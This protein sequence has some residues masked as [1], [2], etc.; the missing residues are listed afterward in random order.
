MSVKQDSSLRRVSL[1]D[2]QRRQQ[3]SL[4]IYASL[5][6][7]SP[8]LSSLSIGLATGLLG[9]FSRRCVPFLSRANFPFPLPW[10]LQ[11]ANLLQV[12]LPPLLEVEP[13]ALRW[14]LRLAL[15]AVHL[16]R[17]EDG[18]EDFG[19]GGGGGGGGSGGSGDGGGGSSVGDVGD[20]EDVA[21]SCRRG[22][23]GSLS[24]SSI[25]VETQRCVRLV[26]ALLKSARAQG[27]LPAGALQQAPTPTRCTRLYAR[28]HTEAAP[29]MPRAHAHESCTRMNRA[30]SVPADA[31]DVACGLAHSSRRRCCRRQVEADFAA[32]RWPVR[33]SLLGSALLSNDETLGLDALELVCV[34]LK[35]RARRRLRRS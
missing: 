32:E 24:E 15:G 4:P 21:H 8:P 30:H 18:G 35:A 33:R 22:G 25:L 1:P 29:H 19:D 10:P 16:G 34:A 26:I 14:T 28:A 3:R 2:S 27:M 31:F 17:G 13:R 5:L 11:A 12:V 20:A 9:S 6:S 23:A 7:F